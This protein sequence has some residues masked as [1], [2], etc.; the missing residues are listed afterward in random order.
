[1]F[2]PPAT[3]RP[4]LRSGSTTPPYPSGPQADF[5]ARDLEKQ[6]NTSSSESSAYPRPSHVP[7]HGLPPSRN[8]FL[9]LIGWPAVVIVA[10][11]VLQGLGWGF[12]GFLKS[13]G[14]VALPLGTVLWMKR[15]VHVVTLLITLLS[16]FLAGCSS[17]LFSF[18]IRRSLSLYLYRPMTLATLGASVGISTRSLASKLLGA[19]TT[20]LT[21]VTIVVSTPLEGTELDLASPLLSEVDTLNICMTN[22]FLGDQMQS[23]Y[24]AANSHLGFPSALPFM[25]HLFNVSTGG[26]MPASFDSISVT[27][28]GDGVNNSIPSTTKFASATVPASGLSSNYSMV[29]QGFTAD[30][31]CSY[32]TLN[33]TTSPSLALNGDQTTGWGSP[34]TDKAGIALSTISSDCPSKNGPEMSAYTFASG[35]FTNQ[36]TLNWVLVISC[37]PTADSQTLIFSSSNKYTETVQTSVCTLKHRVTVVDVDYAGG[38]VNATARASGVPA[39]QGPAASYAALTIANMLYSAQ[40]LANNAVGDVWKTMTTDA[41]ANETET[42]RL[43]EEY[44]RGVLEYSASV[45]RECASLV[46]PA[47]SAFPDGVPLNMTVATSGTYRTET[48]G[49]TYVAR[50]TGWVLIP[51]TL[52]ALATIS[53]MVV[54]LYQHVGHLPS[55]AFDPTDPLH[56]MAAASGGGLA[57]TFSGIGK[58]AMR[59]GEGANVVL[60]WIPDRGPALVRTDDGAGRVL[61]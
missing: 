47:A 38:S 60:G 3:Q 2:S 45:L 44:L 33:S 27:S 55:H 6:D 29:Q 31:S 39:N 42:L 11:I 40:G 7:E 37:D 57:N 1:M 54:A 25:D 36:D 59:V 51:G 24:I 52:L 48:L 16:T 34:N 56:M 12:F 5:D 21:P 43:I 35:L 20:L 41:G 26:V 58:K 28:L 50:T 19:W 30:I 46:G 32:R 22:V 17:F 18:A 49:W 23:G 10:E 61:S 15:N 14:Q 13:R 4:L 8:F 9:K 53:V